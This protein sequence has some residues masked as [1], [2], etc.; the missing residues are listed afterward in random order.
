MWSRYGVI[1]LEIRG[2][3]GVRGDS[4]VVAWRASYFRGKCGVLQVFTAL[5]TSIESASYFRGKC[6]THIAPISSDKETLQELMIT[7]QDAPSSSDKEKL[8]ELT[9]IDPTPSS[10]TP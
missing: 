2:Y 1:I 7:T 10:S 9:A 6:G 8:K 5:L 3:G 4:K